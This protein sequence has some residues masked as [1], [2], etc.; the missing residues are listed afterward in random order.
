[1]STRA[2]F[3]KAWPITIGSKNSVRLVDATIGTAFVEI[4]ENDKGGTRIN[5]PLNTRGWTF[6]ERILS[7]R[8]VFFY[9]D[10][11]SWDC[12]STLIN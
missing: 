10:Q 7:P 11:L 6:Q 12:T 3:K 1:M 4:E 2:Y 9:K 5:E 8:V